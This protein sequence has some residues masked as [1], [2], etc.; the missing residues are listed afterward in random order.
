MAMT[1]AG[2]AG[3]STY[4]GGTDPD[5]NSG[6]VYGTSAGTAEGTTSDFGRGEA[7]RNTPNAPRDQGAPSSTLPTSPLPDDRAVGGYHH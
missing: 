6:V 2:L 4:R 5:A 3:C 7:W 1:L